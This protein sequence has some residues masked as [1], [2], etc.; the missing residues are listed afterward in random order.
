VLDTIERVGAKRLLVDSI[1]D[2]QTGSP[3]TQ[4]F[5]EYMYSLAQ[6][7][8]RQGVSLVLTN[9]LTQRYGADALSDHS[10]SHFCD[11]VSNFHH[12]RAGREIQ[13]TLTVLETRT[14]EHDPSIHN[15]RITPDGI[16]P[17]H[18]P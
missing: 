17:A 9:E 4:R 6:R 10:V 18:G 14:A 8:S 5:P 7:C 12:E 13:R 16:L 15:Y 3:D 11:N 1:G 2:L